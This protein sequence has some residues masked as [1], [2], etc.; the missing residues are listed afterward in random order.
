V[1][2]AH[3]HPSGSSEPS[4]KDIVMTNLLYRGLKIS[5][6]RLLDHF[7]VGCEQVYSMNEHGHFDDFE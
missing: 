1:I 3:N 6:I 7:I 5:E 2:A 4:G